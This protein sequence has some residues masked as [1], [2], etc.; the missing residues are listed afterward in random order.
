MYS[1][2]FKKEVWNLGDGLGETRTFNFFLRAITHF[3]VAHAKI[4]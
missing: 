1:E 2:R 4:N 3:F